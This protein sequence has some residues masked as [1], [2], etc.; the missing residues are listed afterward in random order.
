MGS[1]TL[2]KVFILD[3]GDSITGASNSKLTFMMFF[4]LLNF[5]IFLVGNS[6]ILFIQKTHESK[7]N[8]KKITET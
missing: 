4:T 5:R 1:N 2:G 6:L 8:I 7:A 3:T